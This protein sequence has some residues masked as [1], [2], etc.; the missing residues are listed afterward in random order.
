MIL[1]VTTGTAEKPVIGVLHKCDKI[2]KVRLGYVTQ[3][4]I[5]NFKTL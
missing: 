4:K 5:C 3:L 2:N 1:E